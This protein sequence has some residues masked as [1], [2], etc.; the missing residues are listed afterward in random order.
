[1]MYVFFFFFLATMIY[2]YYRRGKP[3]SSPKLQSSPIAG[4]VKALGGLSL[5]SARDAAIAELEK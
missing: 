4:A 5:S 1:M 3:L 2:Y